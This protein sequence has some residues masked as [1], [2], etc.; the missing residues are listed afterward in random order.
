MIKKGDVPAHKIGKL[1]RF[2]ILK[3]MI[4]FVAVAA[5]ETTGVRNNGFRVGGIAR[6]GY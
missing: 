1:W 6:E 5:P 2:K 3:L 4:G